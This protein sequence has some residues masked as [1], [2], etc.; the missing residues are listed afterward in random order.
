NAGVVT[1]AG[2]VLAGTN[3]QLGKAPSVKLST[4]REP[5]GVIG[6]TEA[7]LLGQL[8]LGGQYM[9]VTGMGNSGGDLGFKLQGV[10]LFIQVGTALGG[11][12]LHRDQVLL[13]QAGIPLLVLTKSVVCAEVQ[14][15]AAFLGFV[16]RCI[17]IVVF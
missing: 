17:E 1:V 12:E 15:E 4:D 9:V 10:P 5:L 3:T 11:F 14:V 13:R 2:Q 16:L 7:F 6:V 8:Q